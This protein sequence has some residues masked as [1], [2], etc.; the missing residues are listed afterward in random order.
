MTKCLVTG[1]AGFIGS[2]LVEA[3][4]EKK[5]K[6]VVLDN[7]STGRKENLPLS[8]S[9][10]E[11]L[12][13]DITDRALL[14]NIKNQHAD[15]DYVFH[16]AA[17]PAVPLSMQDPVNTHRVNFQ[18]TLFLL[19]TFK[20]LALK[21]FVY[22]SSASVYG[23]PNRVPVREDFLPVPL[24]PYGADKLAGEHYLRIFNDSFNVPAVACR[25]FNVFGERQDP[26]SPYSGVISIFFERA[27]AS[28]NG[29]NSSLEIYGDGKQTR[30]F[31]YVKDAVKAWLHLAEEPGIRGEVFNV[32]YGSS[33]SILELAHKVREVLGA[34]I[35]VNFVEPRKG[36]I[37]HS[38]AE[39]Q[40]L[41]DTGLDFDYSF[42][43]GLKRLAEYLEVKVQ[44]E[45]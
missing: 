41:R 39:I 13:G 2:H 44:S 31:I 45:S 43:E 12:E 27:M 29:I 21:K 23:N 20:D 33:T 28:K 40:K 19:D 14:R 26:S 9:G 10:V 15:L 22:A 7:L 24:S 30:D 8:D 42:D 35:D 18:G 6:V 34:D 17:V 38:Q 4:L 32:G 3:C 25:F 36:D 5:S 37:K 1:G 11:F 16:L